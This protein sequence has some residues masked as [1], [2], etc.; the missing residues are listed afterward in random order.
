M[1]KIVLK[2]GNGSS[3]IITTILCKY[4][5]N[6]KIT[7]EKLKKCEVIERKIVSSCECKI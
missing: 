7:T 1:K 5:G 2:N 4:C 3:L 6:F